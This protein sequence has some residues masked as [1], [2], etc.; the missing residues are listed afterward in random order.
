ML[1][2]TAIHNLCSNNHAPQGPKLRKHM[3]CWWWWC[4]V[5]IMSASISASELKSG[6]I[7]PSVSSSSLSESMPMP[8]S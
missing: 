7:A 2:K 1:A 4:F 3:S 8:L 6:V 5:Y